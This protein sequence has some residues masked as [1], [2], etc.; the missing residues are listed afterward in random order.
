MFPNGAELLAYVDLVSNCKSLSLCSLEIREG[1]MRPN[2]E[3]THALICQRF[4]LSMGILYVGG[5]SLSARSLWQQP[6]KA[7]ALTD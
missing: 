1:H 4:G 3:A 7:I 5:P 2:L 6:T